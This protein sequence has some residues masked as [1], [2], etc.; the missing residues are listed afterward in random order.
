MACFV[1]PFWHF[2]SVTFLG[3]EDS[4]RLAWLLYWE[5]MEKSVRSN[6][7]VPILDILK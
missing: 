6:S 2:L 1:L 7:F 5:E 4:A 3:K